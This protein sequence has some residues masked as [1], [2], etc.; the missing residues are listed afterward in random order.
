[1]DAPIK[2]AHHAMEQLPPANRGKY[3]AT[4]IRRPGQVFS[5]THSQ[6][7]EKVA[8]VQTA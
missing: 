4:H 7:A 1:M 5:N 3:L 8:G 6:I 2:M